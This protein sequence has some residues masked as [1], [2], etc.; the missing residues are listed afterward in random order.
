M[1]PSLGNRLLL[2]LCS[3]WN[4]PKSISFR[5]EAHRNH[6]LFHKFVKDVMKA[7]K[8]DQCDLNYV[9]DNLKES[10][11]SK[12]LA[13][14]SLDQRY[15][16]IDKL[17]SFITYVSTF[18]RA[19]TILTISNQLPKLPPKSKCIVHFIHVENRSNSEKYLK[20]AWNGGLLSANNI[21]IVNLKSAEQ[22]ITKLFFEGIF[23]F[24]RLFIV[25]PEVFFS[26]R[27]YQPHV[28]TVTRL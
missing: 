27:Y 12:L 16:Q 20:L 13:N 3:F 17:Y 9:T 14:F 10:E 6:N 4:V 5:I 19:F 22:N 28:C 18:L 2:L 25:E 7:Q 1:F 8:T 24:H 26:Y 21:Y 23:D 11:I 15:L